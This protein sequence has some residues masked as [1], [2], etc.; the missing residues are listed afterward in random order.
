MSST[1]SF[2]HA[3]LLCPS[4]RRTAA[5]FN[6]VWGLCTAPL[7]ASHNG[8]TYLVRSTMVLV[9][10]IVMCTCKRKCWVHA[11]IN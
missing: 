3:T 5:A 6:G 2:H 1:Y 8:I 9:F 10:K 7:E 4:T 11:E